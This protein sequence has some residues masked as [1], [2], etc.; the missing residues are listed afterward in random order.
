MAQLALKYRAD[1]YDLASL[2]RLSAAVDELWSVAQNNIRLEG[3]GLQGLSEVARGASA[4]AFDEFREK[5][6]AIMNAAGNYAQ[7]ELAYRS[8]ISFY[9]RHV[10][11]AGA[12]ASVFSAYDTH[13]RSLTPVPTRAD[14]IEPDGSPSSLGIKLAF[15][16]FT[17][18]TWSQL[19]ALTYINFSRL[20][21]GIR[22]AG[23]TKLGC[24]E[25]QGGSYWCDYDMRWDGHFPFLWLLEL[26]SYR[27]RFAFQGDSW[28]VVE[29]PAQ[30]RPPQPAQGQS[31][32]HFMDMADPMQFWGANIMMNIR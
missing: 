3:V 30:A 27:A 13:V 21:E 29:T 31:G 28:R 24:T 12:L 15:A 17:S 1:R 18:R 20:Y 22:V 25:A 10:P 14:F 19:D 26:K 11:N 2:A 16:E 23:V 8:V 4:N 6:N 5:T 7:R 32:G 9:A